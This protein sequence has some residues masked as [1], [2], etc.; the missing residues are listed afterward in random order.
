MKGLLWLSATITL[1]QVSPSSRGAQALYLQFMLNLSVPAVT[2]LW[3]AP[4]WKV[5][6]HFHILQL[7]LGKQTD[8]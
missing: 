4:F 3:C 5:S 6:N 2:F 7:T 8:E 1:V